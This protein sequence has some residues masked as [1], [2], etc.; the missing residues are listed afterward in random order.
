VK[1]KVK[2]KLPRNKS[3]QLGGGWN[4]GLPPLLWY[5]AQVRTAQLSAVCTDRCLSPRK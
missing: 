5:S 3:W 4:I 1:L 2:V